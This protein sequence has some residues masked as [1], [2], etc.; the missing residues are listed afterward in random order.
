MKTKRLSSRRRRDKR[1]HH[2]TAR[3]TR[4]DSGYVGQLVEWPEVISE[5]RSLEDCQESLRDALYEMIRA[6]RQ[7]R[8]EIPTSGSLTEQI[9]VEIDSV[10]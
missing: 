6:Y 7:L 4:T 10:R 3:Y 2:F 8:R 1:V 9:P 5:G